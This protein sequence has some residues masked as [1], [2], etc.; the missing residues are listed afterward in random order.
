MA[1]GNNKDALYR[2]AK[3]QIRPSAEQAAVLIQELCIQRLQYSCN[4]SVVFTL[5][6]A[7]SP[8]HRTQEADL[9]ISSLWIPWQ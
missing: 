9:I 1:K 7:I 4:A 5:K 2:V 6:Q 3:F 8:A